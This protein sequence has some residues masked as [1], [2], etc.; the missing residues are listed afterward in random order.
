MRPFYLLMSD[1][2]EALLGE[3]PQRVDVCPHVQLAAH[4]HHFGVGTK[5]LRLTLP[6][7]TQTTTLWVA[8]FLSF[9]FLHSHSP[10]TLSNNQMSG[11]ALGSNQAAFRTQMRWE[12][13]VGQ[14]DFWKKENISL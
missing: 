1:R 9:F 12:Q 2:D 11:L 7:W 8:F 14:S 6:L 4:Q 3:F 5:L 10:Q 13:K